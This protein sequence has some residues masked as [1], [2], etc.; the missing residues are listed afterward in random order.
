MGHSALKDLEVSLSAAGF[1]VSK[2]DPSSYLSSYDAVSHPHR[3][4]PSMARAGF[5]PLFVPEQRVVGESRW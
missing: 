4:L 1:K 5:L 2:A 3:G